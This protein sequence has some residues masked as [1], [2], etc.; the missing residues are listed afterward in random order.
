[1]SKA[2]FTAVINLLRAQAL[3]QE[4]FAGELGSVH[5]L[6]LN[7]ALLLMHLEKAPLRRLTRVDL[8]KRLH[9]SPST[10]TRMA[11]PMEKTGLISRQS[12]PRDARLAYVVLT[13]AGLTLVGDVRKTIER[14]SA[15]LF[16][17]RW[18]D[19]EIASL[20]KMLGRLTAGELGD[21]V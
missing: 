7:E 12:D 8:A 5:G 11:A 4:R 15:E 9:A 3:L 2:P 20:A 13:E 19:T 21:L 10:V 16:R 14:R 1:M 6:A 18:S 17:D